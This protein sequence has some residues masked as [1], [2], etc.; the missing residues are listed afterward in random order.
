MRSHLKS[1]IKG[2]MAFEAFVW[3]VWGL[4]SDCSVKRKA[5][6]RSQKTHWEAAVE[7]QAGEGGNLAQDCDDT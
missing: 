3:S 5:E 4:C 6:H 7:T 2:M 1:L